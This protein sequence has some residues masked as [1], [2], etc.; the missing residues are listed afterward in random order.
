MRPSDA[1][2]P[3]R[4]GVSSCLLGEEVR[5]DGGHK[6]DRFLTDLLGRYVEWVP[7]CPEV[8]VGMGVPR[9]ALRLVGTPASPRMIGLRSGDDYTARM[10]RFATE[11]VRALAALDLG[12]YVFK[13]DSPSCGIERVR[14]YGAGGA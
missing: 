13:K 8:E 1:E 6:R 12:G 4:L 3:L 11:R 5:F 10:R 7:V 2:P 14:V 9:E